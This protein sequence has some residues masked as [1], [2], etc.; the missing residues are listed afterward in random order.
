MVAMNS[1]C[2][3]SWPD[4]FQ[5]TQPAKD[6]RQLELGIFP[7]E[8]LAM[9]KKVSDI[10]PIEE[11]VAKFTAEL[12][13][14]IVEIA[15]KNALTDEKWFAAAEVLSKAKNAGVKGTVHFGQLCKILG[16]GGYSNGTRLVKTYESKAVAK[17]RSSG[18]FCPLDGWS[19][20]DEIR[21]LAKE[22]DEGMR[23]LN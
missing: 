15:A 22:G 5:Q 11:L 10:V 2:R 17:L 6:L 1:A 18:R 13:S 14:I 9:S 7:R 8:G 4:I 21:L 12:Q 16:R 23:K 20:W 3:S 19:F